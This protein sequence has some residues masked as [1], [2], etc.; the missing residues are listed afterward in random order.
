M[1]K[2]NIGLVVRTYDETGCFYETREDKIS[3]KSIPDDVMKDLMSGEVIRVQLMPN[4][5]AFYFEVPKD[6]PKNWTT[7]KDSSEKHYQHED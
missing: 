3:C 7:L 5:E 1:R 6:W 4:V 2:V